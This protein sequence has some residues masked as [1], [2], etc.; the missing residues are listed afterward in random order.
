MYQDLK[1]LKFVLYAR[2]STDRDDRQVQSIDDQIG[3]MTKL[4]SERGLKIIHIIRESKSAKTPGKRPGFQEML[5]MVNSSK[6]NGI[7]TWQLNRL[8]RNP[9]EGGEI[10]WLLQE[11][12]IKAIVTSEKDYLPDDNALPISVEGGMANQYIR[13]LSKNV[14]RGLDK[15]ISGG[16]FGAFSPLGYLND[17][18]TKTIIKDPVR[19]PLV[20][21]MWDMM[22]T[23]RYSPNQI[24]IIAN[25][26]W[27]FK[28]RTT[29]NWKGG[30]LTNS[31]IYKMFNNTFY[32][33]VITWKGNETPG[34][35]EPMVTIAE[36]NHVQNI[37]G[38][39][40][41]P[42]PK[43]KSFAFTGI[44]FCGECGC[45]ITAEDKFKVIQSNGETKKYTYYHCTHRKADAF[46]TQGS[47][48]EQEL[49]R[50][51]VEFLGRYT[52]RPEFRDWVLNAL[53]ESQAVEKETR[54]IL[55]LKKIE[56]V[57]D[58]EKKR[59]GL[60][61]MKLAGTLTDEEF[62][63]AKSRYSQ[64][65]E[66][67]MV[68]LETLNADESIW[69]ELV[70]RAFNFAVNAR[71]AFLHGDLETKKTILMGLGSNLILK[72]KKLDITPSI[73]L[74]PIGEGTSP[75]PE[76]IS[77]LEPLKHAVNQ[78]SQVPLGPGNVIWLGR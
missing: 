70:T 49:E 65:R 54:L 33:G 30:P 46:C 57:R 27:G 66:R 5:D 51:V 25:E 67:L 58:V 73:W 77:T 72:D 4:A 10:V 78:G 6:A 9:R 55:H 2:K 8:F 34:K 69:T 7:I 23:G 56:E 52:I 64:D 53:M 41:R 68:E 42:H 62:A 28:T 59:D 35:H 74:A 18:A 22:L 38:A 15:K 76:D 44:I 13:E 36:F 45:V 1:N 48:T 11:E 19:F 39:K 12:I 24:R 71:Q 29:T 3:R 17:Q 37:L 43:T 26:D 40:G 16:W 60:L 21:R 14:K 20:R 31:G 47:I 32:K 63:R 75:S 61:D 50:Q